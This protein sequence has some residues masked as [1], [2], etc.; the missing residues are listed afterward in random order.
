M[1]KKIKLIV[2][3]VILGFAEKVFAASPTEAA[4][5][6][7]EAPGARSAALGEAFTTVSNDIT[8]FHYNPAALNTLKTGQASFLFQRGAVEDS[9]GQ[10]MLGIPREN[11]TYGFSVGYYDGG[12]TQVF[13]GQTITNV[14]SQ[15]DLAVGFGYAGDIHGV[16]F[17]V[18]GKYFN[19]DLGE[20]AS[21]DALAGDVGLSVPV[22]ET[23][24][25]GLSLQNFGSKLKFVS[26]RQN[27]PRVLRTGLSWNVFHGKN[28]TQFFLDAPY[29]F[30]QSEIRPAVGIETL[31][32]PLA[33]RLGYKNGS[34]LE[35]FSIGTGFFIGR[36]SLDYSFGLVD[37][38][39]SRHRLSFSTRFGSDRNVNEFVLFDPTRIREEKPQVV[40]EKLFPPSEPFVKDNIVEYKSVVKKPIDPSGGALVYDVQEGDTFKSIAKQKY[41]YAGYWDSIYLMNKHLMS[42]PNELRPG[43]KILIPRKDKRTSW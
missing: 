22:F 5:T 37:E 32:G 29:F 23:V 24:R 28:S 30:N 38:L 20:R 3:V 16:S 13:D 11:E 12:D 31:F 33:V 18:T 19:S 41:G 25:V 26:E 27:L 6:L 1:D 43:M 35:E 42:D 15:Q 39:N 2:C 36:S 14:K 7:L 9:Y 10:L 40:Q 21:A 4:L 34:D 17:G 8:A